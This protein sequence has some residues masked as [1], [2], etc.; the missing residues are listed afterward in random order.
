MFEIVNLISLCLAQNEAQKNETFL[1][2]AI[3]AII[4]CIF[5]AGSF[6]P[7]PFTKEKKIQ[8]PLLVIAA[9][10]LFIFFIVYLVYK[11]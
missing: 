2:L 5:I 4:A 11:K 10:I 7:K 8:K 3:F 1:L 6:G 9:M